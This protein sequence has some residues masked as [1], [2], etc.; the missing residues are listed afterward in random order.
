MEQVDS[1]KVFRVPNQLVVEPGGKYLP[2]VY[3]FYT[4]DKTKVDNGAEIVIKMIMKNSPI[5]NH[6]E[7]CGH[8]LVSQVL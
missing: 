5:L 7:V 4:F 1:S 3:F 8:N 6:P 2:F